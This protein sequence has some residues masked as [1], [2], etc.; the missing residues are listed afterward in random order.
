[1]WQV[2]KTERMLFSLLSALFVLMAGSGI[3]AAAEFIVHNGES[4]QLAVDNAT[5]GDTIIVEPGMYNESVTVQSPITI[6]SE[7]GNPEDT[8][9]QGS[10]FSLYTGNVAIKGFTLKGDS[11]STGIFLSDSAI[12]CIIENNNIVNYDTGIS[13]SIY[14][15]G[16]AVNNNEISNCGKGVEIGESWDNLVSNNE[17]SNCDIGVIIDDLASAEIKSNTITDNG[18]GVSITGD[19]NVSIASNTISFNSECGLYNNAYGSNTIYDN[20]FNNTKNVIFDEFHQAPEN[21]NTTKNKDTNIMGG[22]YIAGNY[23]AE[24]EGTGFSQL[25]YDANSDGIAE[26]PYTIDGEDIDFMPLVI[27]GEQAEPLLPVANF[28]ANTS[29]GSA[30]LSVSF[31]DLSKNAVSWSW[32]FENDGKIDSTAKNGVHVFTVPGSYKVNHTVKNEAGTASK[33]VTI[34]VTEAVNNK[35]ENDGTSSTGTIK[36]NGNNS[37]NTTDGGNSG[38][39]NENNSV[40]SVNSSVDNGNSNVNNGNSGVDSGINGDNGNSGDSGDSSSGSSGGS[41][42]GGAGVSPEPQTN[43]EVKELSQAFITN[44]EEAKFDFSKNA[45]CVVYVSFDAKK[46]LGKITTITEMLKGKSALVSELPVGDVYK[47]FNI[48]VGNGGIA[49]SDNMENLTVCFKVE[50]SWL[51]EKGID[52]ASIALNWYNDK[53]WKQF[54]VNI[55]G[56]D[57]NY[58]YFTANVSGYSSFAITGS[59]DSAADSITGKVKSYLE[60][61]EDSEEENN[62]L[63]TGSARLTSETNDNVI[64]GETEKSAPGFEMIFGIICLLGNFLYRRK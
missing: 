16:T 21:W 5:S 1:V 14:C 49:T 60:Q 27:L 28:K 24:P 26:E 64:K 29:Q 39:N 50:K 25:N 56:E 2:N 13:T 4:I 10:G 57:V 58:L 20:L 63:G 40:G 38:L 47:S 19:C 3:S 55:S 8:I 9:I 11:E 59:A 30:P 34:T 54:P 44:G 18:V 31:T 51:Q 23:W 15:S 45:T 6:V 36:N 33:L 62:L 46:T 35:S 48:W 61:Q 12:S 42:G 32:D 52:P 22:P 53:K 7:S 37:S 41:G 43:I 17:I